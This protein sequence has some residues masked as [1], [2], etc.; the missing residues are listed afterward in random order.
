MKKM[1]SILLSTILA[2]GSLSV[3]AACGDR[4]SEDGGEAIDP[5]R[6]QLYVGV[7]DGALGTEWFDLYDEAYEASHPDI[8]VILD[9]KKNEYGDAQL[10]ST[11]KDS[12]QDVY[13][14]SANNYS[15]Y[16][17]SDLLLD[18]TD[19]VTEKVY[20]EEM[21]LVGA[22]MGTKSIID[23]MY[24]DFQKVY[25]IQEGES[26]KYYGLPNWISPAG[27]I[28]DAG[29]FEDS[30]YGY[31]V[32]ETYEEFKQLWAMME[33]DGITAFAFSSFDYI[34][35][36]ALSG[37]WAAYEGKANYELNN[38]FSGSYTFPAGSLTSEEMTRWNG[39]TESDGSQTVTITKENAF[40]LQRQ[41]GKEAALQFMYDLAHNTAYTTQGTR[42]NQL[43]TNAQDEFVGSVSNPTQNRVAMLLESSYWESEAKA[44]IQSVGEL[45]RDPSMEYGKRDFRF[46]PFPK[47]QGSTN[48]KTT[49]F[50]SNTSSMVC[51]NA[52]TDVPDI[53][54]DFVQ[55][56]HDRSNLAIYTQYTSSIRP[57]YYEMT[58]AE[59]EKCTPFGQSIY[60]LTQDENVEFTYD[61][62]YSDNEITKAGG[63]EF[64]WNWKFMS[65]ITPPSRNPFSSF[66]SN[67]SLTVD[68][69][70]NGLKA[71]W[72]E[73]NWQTQIR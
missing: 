1:M 2:A 15:V 38:S 18:I 26:V 29:L 35:H 67:Q 61:L 42:A 37:V 7:F 68:A 73:S 22:E 17:D 52:A 19:C 53:A 9:E 12:R 32:P 20:D 16:V 69:Y 23:M 28:Y 41:P 55:F 31:E 24:P 58:S 44:T 25:G 5:N 65:D 21:N 40:L 45:L 13:F 27:V 56:V 33:S 59:L 63:E 46:M 57:F 48:D 47:M 54:K 72:S 49:V 30:T 10:V 8:Q 34:L 4:N 43:N 36:S 39:T 71:H 11:M 70:W 66:Y 51:V 62:I 6:T 50:C 64:M 3:F 14:L 60:A